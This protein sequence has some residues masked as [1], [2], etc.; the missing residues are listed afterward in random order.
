MMQKLAMMQKKLPQKM[1]NKIYRKKN[2]KIK[3]SKKKKPKIKM[4]KIKKLMIKMSKM[5]KLMIKMS[6]RIPKMKP[7]EIMKKKV[8]KK[9]LS[10][11]EKRNARS[12]CL[13]TIHLL[14]H[15]R[16]E[17]KRKNIRKE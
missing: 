7:I 10:K 11:K 4:S 16:K 17:L 3:M 2:P 12:K 9:H 14:K 13:L 1:M 6:K 8:L 15:G 5:K